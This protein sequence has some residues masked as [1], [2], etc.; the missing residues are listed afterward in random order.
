MT[1]NPNF[2][3]A[4]L[5]YMEGRGVC[6]S[7]RG[8]RLQVDAPCGVMTRDMLG[9]LREAKAEVIYELRLREPCT[10]C[11]AGTAVDTPIHGG[12]SIRRDCA[13]CGL[14]KGFPAWSSGWVGWGKGR[15]HRHN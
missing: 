7:L 2:G 15:D 6:F 10:R 1:G 5:A 8:I 14:T 3:S 13:V 12:R 4:L 11:G 9:A